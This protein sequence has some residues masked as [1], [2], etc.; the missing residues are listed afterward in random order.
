MLGSHNIAHRIL[1]MNIEGILYLLRIPFPG[2]KAAGVWTQRAFR[3][4]GRN[5]ASL[6]DPVLYRHLDRYKRAVRDTGRVLSKVTPSGVSVGLVNYEQK[7]LSPVKSE[8]L[9]TAAEQPELNPFYPYFR[10]RL[11]GLFHEKEPSL[12]GFSVNYLSQALTAFSMLGFV[13][14][15]FPRMK[16]IMGGGL[17]TSWLKNPRWK[18][19]FAGMADHLVA[20]PGEYQLL[21]LLGHNVTK[22]EMPRPDYHALPKDHCLSPGF[23]LPYSASSGCYWHNCSFCPEK[24]EGNPYVPIPSPRVIADLKAL[25][26]TNAPALIHLLDNAVSPALLDA[27]SRDPIGVPWYGFARIGPPLTD[28]DFCMALKRAGCVMLKLGIESGDQGVLDALE[29]GTSVEAASAV[30]ENLKGAGIAA[31]VYLLFGTP[32]E[33]E[34]AAK[35]TLEFTAKYSNCIDFLNLAI[36]NMPVCGENNPGIETREFYEGDLS[37][38]TDF[39]HPHGWDRKRVRIFLEHEFRKHPAVSAILKNEPPLFTSNHAPFFVMRR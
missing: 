3:N 17:I 30:L 9:L 1:D 37:L 8:D 21:S 10:S 11:E 4:S 31:Y 26:E 7:G 24:A 18:N 22:K 33:T 34:A 5:I 36:F 23:I 12:A 20:G 14:R 6:K 19:P 25:R 27:L 16:V 29:K 15:E 28:P 35:K 32:A 2:K 13:R 38:Y 39:V